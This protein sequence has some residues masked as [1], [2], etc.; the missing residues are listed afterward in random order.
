MAY[1]RVH[2]VHQIL[3]NKYWQLNEVAMVLS[4]SWV[5]TGTAKRLDVM[6]IYQCIHLRSC[7]SQLPN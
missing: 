1:M 2:K 3:H 4:R 7:R 5:L 6:H